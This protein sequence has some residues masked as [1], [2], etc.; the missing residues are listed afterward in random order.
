MPAHIFIPSRCDEQAAES[1][2]QHLSRLPPLSSSPAASLPVNS[3]VC[4]SNLLL[5]GVW[6]LA[7]RRPV[8]LGPC[9]GPQISCKALARRHPFSDAG[10]MAYRIQS[11]PAADCHEKRGPPQERRETRHAAWVV[12]RASNSMSKSGN[13]IQMVEYGPRRGILALPDTQLPDDASSLKRR[14]GGGVGPTTSPA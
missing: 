14:P 11:A 13:V 4:G 7:K 2:P 5:P 3:G 6:T 8:S 1:R 10:A 9:D 12:A